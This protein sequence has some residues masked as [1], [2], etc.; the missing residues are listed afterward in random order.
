MNFVYTHFYKQN[1]SNKRFQ[2]ATKQ[3]HKEKII[4]KPY[5]IIP[6]TNSV[7]MEWLQEFHDMRLYNIQACPITI[8]FL[9][10]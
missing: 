9:S 2:A 5:V 4:V 1:N 7:E 6:K 8:S 3:W 10:A